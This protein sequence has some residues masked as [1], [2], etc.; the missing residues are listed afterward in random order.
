MPNRNRE[1]LEMS[2]RYEGSHQ[3][4]ELGP[5][6]ARVSSRSDM[7]R[8]EL[9]ALLRAERFEIERRIVE[10]RKVQTAAA[11]R[12]IDR[13][14]QRVRVINHAHGEGLLREPRRA[15]HPT[16]LPLQTGGYR[17]NAPAGYPPSSARCW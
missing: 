6:R 17:A 1:D 9:L 14:E 8:P 4:V 12:E 10:Y 16:P 2:D 5:V 3:R 15:G 13:L 11:Q 7:S